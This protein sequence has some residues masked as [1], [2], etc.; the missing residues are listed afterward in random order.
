[1][2]EER[3]KGKAVFL[4]IIIKIIN[5][6]IF[7]MFYDVYEE[8]MFTIEIEDGCKAPYKP[9]VIKNS[10]GKSSFWF[11]FKLKNSQKKNPKNVRISIVYGILYKL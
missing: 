11:D 7:Y 10:A 2:S 1:M 8:N 3:G 9:I 5:H 6:G 4:R